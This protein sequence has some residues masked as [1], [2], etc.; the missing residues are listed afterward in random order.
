ML[1]RVRW[2]NQRRGFGFITPEPES[3]GPDKVS[4][5]FV[6]YSGIEGDGFKFLRE[7]DKVTYDLEATARGLQAVRVRIEG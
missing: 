5:I 2:F 3:Q 6:H 1:G 7:G 4:D